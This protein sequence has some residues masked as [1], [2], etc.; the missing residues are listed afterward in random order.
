MVQVCTTSFV[1]QVKHIATER[2]TTLLSAAPLEGEERVF[3]NTTQDVH[4]AAPEKLGWSVAEHLLHRGQPFASKAGFDSA[5]YAMPMYDADSMQ[6]RD[7]VLE[8]AHWIF[9]KQASMAALFLC[10]A[11]VD[12][13]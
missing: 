2:T 11:S 13:S 1:F 4:N 8:S 6:R 5:R 10:F 3:Y 9:S 7:H 12:A